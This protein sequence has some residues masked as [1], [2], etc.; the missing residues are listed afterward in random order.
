[1]LIDYTKKKYKKG[2]GGGD[3]WGGWI[4]GEWIWGERGGGVETIAIK[5]NK[6]SR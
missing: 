4:D 6:G 2:K 5:I 1:M 3:R